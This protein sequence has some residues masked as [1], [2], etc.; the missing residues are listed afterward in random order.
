M[1]SIPCGSATITPPSFFTPPQ[2]PP[3]LITPLHPTPSVS[4]APSLVSILIYL[5][6]MT[7][8]LRPD[9]VAKVWW[10]Q[11]LVFKYLVIA[12][13]QQ[14][15]SYHIMDTTKVSNLFKYLIPVS[16]RLKS[17]S[18]SRST[19]GKEIINRGEKQLLQERIKCINGIYVTIGLG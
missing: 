5:F 3:I 15:S 8:S 17:A 2:T 16:V 10:L 9:E 7:F 1:V 11:K 19:R 14:M 12:L 18:N 13:F 4:V 6:S